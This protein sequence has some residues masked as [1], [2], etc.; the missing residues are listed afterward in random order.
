MEN[1]FEFTSDWFSG[2]IA[3]WTQWLAHL[4]DKPTAA[5]EIG[6]FEGR[7][8]C[9]LMESILTHPDSR[10]F[11]IDTWQ[12]GDDLPAV[13]DDSLLHRFIKNTAP[14]SR[15]I[16]SLRTASKNGLAWLVSERLQFDFIYVDGSH[17]APD[18]LLDAVMGWNLLS[19]GGVMVFDDY[20]W[21]QDPNPV[22]QPRLA[23]DAFLQIYAG[24]Y[25]VVA[26]GYQVVVKKPA[27][28]PSPLP[29][30]LG[31]AIAE[32]EKVVAP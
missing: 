21:C 32:R 24:Q 15:K 22:R 30:N 18:V 1:Q 31:L 11:C 3:N 5:L 25:E 14:Y 27:P 29:P 26:K 23:I 16:T 10:L 12:A 2:N 7:S 8:A 20:T 28:H 6:S 13:Q 19:P 17:L 4:K 9:W